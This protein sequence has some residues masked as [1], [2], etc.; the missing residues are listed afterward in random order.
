MFPHTILLFLCPP[1]SS[2]LRTC[3]LFCGFLGFCWCVAVCRTRSS[4]TTPRAGIRI[5]RIV[6]GILEGWS[7]SHVGSANEKFLIAFYVHG[8]IKLT[9][10]TLT[11]ENCCFSPPHY[12][13][14]WQLV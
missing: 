14:C 4:V 12:I 10:N 13:L 2:A 11:C 9:L 3:L 1:P 8:T 5:L 7:V 6:S